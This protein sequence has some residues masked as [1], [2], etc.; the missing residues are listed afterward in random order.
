MLFVGLEASCRMLRLIAH[1][2]LPPLKHDTRPPLHGADPH[3]Q[4]PAGVR[5]RK[6]I[7]L[8]ALEEL[9][10]RFSQLVAEQRWIEEID[11]NPLLASPIVSPP[12][13]HASSSTHRPPEE[14][15]LRCHPAL[16]EARCAAA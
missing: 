10:V 14:N 6:P 3:L 16:S 5:G 15:I 13:M 4:G 7:D 8:S 9:L 2:A 12:S 1:S 11:I